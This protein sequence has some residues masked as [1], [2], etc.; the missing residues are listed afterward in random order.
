MLH[1]SAMHMSQRD[2]GLQRDKERVGEDTSNYYTLQQN[3]PL[4]K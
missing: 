1:Y 2:P 4:F 3:V